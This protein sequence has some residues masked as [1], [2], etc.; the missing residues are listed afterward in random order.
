MESIEI[1]YTWKRNSRQNESTYFLNERKFRLKTKIKWI[2]V[3]KKYQNM[4]K[5]GRE[6]IWLR[7][8]LESKEL[9]SSC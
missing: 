7:L 1:L 3:K 5:L 8:S 6:S 9:I 2:S 4:D